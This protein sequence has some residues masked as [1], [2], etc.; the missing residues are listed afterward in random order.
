MKA[1][2]SINLW[3]ITFSTIKGCLLSAF[4]LLAAACPAIS[5]TTNI[6]PALLTTNVAASQPASFLA[7]DADAKEYHPKP[8]ELTAH[9]TFYVTNVA[10]EEVIIS[11]LQRSCGCTEAK[12]PEQPWRLAP[13]T[14]GAIEATIDLRGKGGRISKTLTVH[15]SA[16]LKTLLLNVNIPPASAPTGAF[17]PDRSR[18]LQI[19]GQDRQAVFKGECAACHAETTAGKSGRELYQAGCAICHDAQN[20]AA[21]V[22]DLRALQHPTNAEHWRQWIGSSKPG[23]LMPAFAKSAGGPLSEEQIRSLVDYLTQTVPS[24]PSVRTNALNDRKENSVKS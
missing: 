18:N 22:P 1:T 2:H 3:T 21:M 23:S 12:M 20:R 24:S 5:Q 15:S 6:S 9:F 14:N 16:G 11:R 8:G 4:S 7:W 10:A 17:N 13:G 19:A